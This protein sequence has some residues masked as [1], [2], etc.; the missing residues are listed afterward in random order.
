[1]EIHD[2]MVSLGADK[3]PGPDGFNMRFYQYFWQLLR[4]DFIDIFHAFY[5]GHIDLS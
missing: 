5:Y 2:A 3:V 4:Q 1:M